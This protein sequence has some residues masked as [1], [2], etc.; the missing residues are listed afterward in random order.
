MQGSASP[1]DN[2]ELNG[3][4]TNRKKDSQEPFCKYEDYHVMEDYEVVVYFMVTLHYIT[5]TTLKSRNGHVDLPDLPGGNK[6]KS[7]QPLS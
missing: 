7:L 1:P 4:I 2:M 3:K 6:L 5:I